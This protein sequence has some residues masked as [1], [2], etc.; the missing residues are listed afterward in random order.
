VLLGYLPDLK[1]EFITNPRER[2]EMKWQVYHAAMRLMLDLLK[3]AGHEGIEVRCADGGVRRGYPIVSAQIG[4]WMEVCTAACSFHTRCPMCIDDYEER[5]ELGEPAILRTKHQTLQAIL[6]A[7]NQYTSNSKKLGLRPTWPYW[8][9]LPYANGA[10]LIVP[11][12][13]HQIHKGMFKTHLFEWWKNIHGDEEI[14]RRFKGLPRFHGLRHFSHR[15][16][17]ISQWTRN[18]AKQVERTFLAVIADGKPKGALRATRALMGFF[19]RAHLPQVD[20]DD[21]HQMEVDLETFHQHKEIFRT[22]GVYESKY[23]W[24]SISK[25]HMLRHFTHQIRKMGATDSYTTET[26]ERLHK[27]YVKNPYRQTSK[28]QNTTEQM[29]IRFQQ[30]EAWDIAQARLERAGKIPKLKLR[31]R[32]GDVGDFGDEETTVEGEH[33]FA[34]ERR[35]EEIR[36]RHGPQLDVRIKEVSIIQLTPHLD[37]AKRPT[38]EGQSLAQV[39][40]AH[41]APGLWAALQ[42]YVNTVDV[43]LTVQLSKTMTIGVWSF[44]K[45]IHDPLPFA[46]LVGSLTDFVQATPAKLDASGRKTREPNYNTVLIETYPTRKGIHSTHSLLLQEPLD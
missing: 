8:A 9:D 23:G 6:D 38:R 34:V 29:L 5:G 39:A 21:H 13:L 14:D 32:V 12:L 19:F 40:A 1:L 44:C 25:L 4:D 20:E 28:S 17:V 42:D 46:P 26:T 7:M 2:R 24:H 16:S 30:E 31:E 35:V 11:D 36:P 10:Q 37:I 15:L 45:L 43:D 27:Y 41:Q 33:Q 3:K 18:E 22:C